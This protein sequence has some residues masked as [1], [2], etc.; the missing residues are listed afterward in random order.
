MDQLLALAAEFSAWLAL[1][2]LVAMEIALGVDSLVFVETHSSQSNHRDARARLS[3]FDRR[4]V[5][6]RRIWLSFSQGLHLRRDGLSA[7]VEGR[8]MLARRSRKPRPK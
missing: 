1:V 6:C 3:P 8:N 2:T 5:D 4:D 7:A